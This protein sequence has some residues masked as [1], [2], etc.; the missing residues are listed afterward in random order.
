[1]TRV[2]VNPAGYIFYIPS[3]RINYSLRNHDSFCSVEL[4]IRV[5]MYEYVQNWLET[6]NANKLLPVW[7]EKL[8]RSKDSYKYS[9]GFGIFLTNIRYDRIC[10][11]QPV[12]RPPTQGNTNTDKTH[13][14]IHVRSG[15]RIQDPNQNYWN[16]GLCQSSG[17]L[18]A[19]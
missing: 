10:R 9:P 3:L 17:I 8:A 13:P 2:M 4:R 6:R 19:R 1:M 14:Y 5:W 16:I 11:D 18:K 12:T 15:I 7:Y